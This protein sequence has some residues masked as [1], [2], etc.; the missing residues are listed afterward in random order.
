MIILLLSIVYIV[1][2]NSELLY[3]DENLS[4]NSEQLYYDFNHFN[5]PSS[6][7]K[8]GNK[9]NKVRRLIAYTGEATSYATNNQYSSSASCDGSAI[10]TN[11]YIGGY[12]IE[13]LFTS[14]S[15]NGSAYFASSF[16]SNDTHVIRTIIFYQDSTCITPFLWLSIIPI[17]STTKYPKACK[18]TTDNHGASSE[19][20][21]TA[22]SGN[23]NK[24][25]SGVI[26]VDIFFSN[27]C[28]GPVHQFLTQQNGICMSENDNGVKSSRKTDCHNST[29]SKSESFLDNDSCSGK[30]STVNFIKM[31]C[32]AFNSGGGSMQSSCIPLK[33]DIY[34]PKRISD[35]VYLAIIGILPIFALIYIYRAKLFNAF[36]KKGNESK[37]HID[38]SQP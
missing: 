34:M 32:S 8:N 20:Y 35:L 28:T 18:N 14:G 31:G 9:E 1:S 17:I 11:T 4:I 29:H 37:V 27:D 36:S 21:I 22:S 7:I 15:N 25:F 10:L 3:S 2:I 23:P 12:C 38:Q 13:T 19:R 30:A 24:D 6:I 33:E 16:K 26:L 5:G